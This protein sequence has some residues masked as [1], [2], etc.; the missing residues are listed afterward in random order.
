MLDS[1][2][3]TPACMDLCLPRRIPEI[4]RQRGDFL[5]GFRVDKQKSPARFCGQE[6]HPRLTAGVKRDSMKAF[7]GLEEGLAAARK[8]QGH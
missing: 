5:P 3:R 7:R 4:L 2:K 8:S 6:T 1:G